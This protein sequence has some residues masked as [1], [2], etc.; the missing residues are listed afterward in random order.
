MKMVAMVV[1]ELR[2]GLIKHFFEF[3]NDLLS[4]LPYYYC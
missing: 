1:V 2:C 4:F 3:T